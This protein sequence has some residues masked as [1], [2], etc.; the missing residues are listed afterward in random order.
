M[1]LNDDKN[2]DPKKRKYNSKKRNKILNKIKKIND[3]KIYLLIYKVINDDKN[4]PISSNNN[5]IF[6][7]MNLLK[8]ESIEKIS[9][10]IEENIDESS[11]STDTNFTYTPYK[12]NNDLCS[13]DLDVKLSNKEKNLLKTINKK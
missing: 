5:G 8:D 9:N 11:S 10:I 2:E 4:C 1:D 13:E 12:E 6:F 7:D 3:K